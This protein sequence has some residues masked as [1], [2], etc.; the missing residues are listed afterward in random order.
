MDMDGRTGFV[1]GKL[2]RGAFYI[3]VSTP[4]SIEVMLH[5]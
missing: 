3:S 4:Q 5:V 1:A 2:S